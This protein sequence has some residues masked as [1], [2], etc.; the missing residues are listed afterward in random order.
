M[1]VMTSQA[2]QVPVKSTEKTGDGASRANRLL[3]F[4]TAGGSDFEVG[5][6]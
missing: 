4:K 1:R 6:E 3:Q 2:R 5:L